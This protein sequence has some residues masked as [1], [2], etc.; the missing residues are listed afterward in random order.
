MAIADDVLRVNREAAQLAIMAYDAAIEARADEM[1]AQGVA[2]NAHRYWLDV[3]M[4]RAGTQLTVLKGMG[5]DI[6]Q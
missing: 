5:K 6:P 1:T 3:L 4:S 2:G